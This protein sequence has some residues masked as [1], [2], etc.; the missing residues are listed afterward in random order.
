[1]FVLAPAFPVPK[2]YLRLPPAGPP[3]KGSRTGVFLCGLTKP[4]PDHVVRE[5]PRIFTSG[6]KALFLTRGH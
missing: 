5:P 2:K 1:M 6:H 3:A 4:A